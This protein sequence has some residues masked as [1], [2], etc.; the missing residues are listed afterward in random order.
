MSAWEFLSLYTLTVTLYLYIAARPSPASPPLW[1]CAHTAHVPYRTA[2]YRTTPYRTAPY[3]TVSQARAARG[4]APRG[5]TGVLVTHC[6]FICRCRTHG[7]AGIYGLLTHNATQ[8]YISNICIVIFYFSFLIS[9]VYNFCLGSTR[10]CSVR[11]RGCD[12]LVV[13]LALSGLRTLSVLDSHDIVRTT[14]RWLT[15]QNYVSITDYCCDVRLLYLRIIYMF[16]CLSYVYVSDAF[17]IVTIV[18][19]RLDLFIII[20]YLYFLVPI[21]YINHERSRYLF[22]CL[23]VQHVFAQLSRSLARLGPRFRL[24]L[25]STCTYYL[26]LSSSWMLFLF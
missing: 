7:S 4:R 3:R 14:K 17:L 11:E 24:D 9:Y 15:T 16:M 22:I 5:L 18:L 21:F 6:G 19:Y 10:S 20:F 23:R 8:W 2:A 12:C 13:S 26:T 25:T 1:V